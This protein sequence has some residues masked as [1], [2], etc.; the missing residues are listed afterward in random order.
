MPAPGKGW[1]Q[2]SETLHEALGMPSTAEKLQDRID[3]DR[4]ASLEEAEHTVTAS[5]NTPEVAEIA[6]ANL[7]MLAGLA[8]PMVFKYLFPPILITVWQLMLSK[9][10]LPGKQF[11]QIALGIP[12]GFAKTTIVK[13]FV[14]WCILFSSKK[15]IMIISRTGPNAE[16]ILADIIDMLEERNI[17]NLFGHWKLAIEVDRQNLKKFVFRGRTV[18]LAAMGVGGSIRGLNI[19]NE[20]PDIMIFDD[21]QDRDDAESQI[22]SAAI[23]RWMF[24]T[25]MKAKSPHGCI[26]IFLANMFPTEHSILKK[27]KKNKTWTKFISGA[28]LADYTS[29]WEDLRSLDSLIEELNNDIEAGHPEIFFSEVLNDTDVGINTRVDLSA[30]KAWPWSASDQPQGKFIIIDPS[31]NK[32]GGDD[33]AIGYAEVYDGTP[34]LKEVIEERLSPGNTIR[35]ALVMAFEHNTNCI[36]CESNGYQSTLLYWFGIVCNQLGIEGMHLLEVYSSSVS[37]NSRITDMLKSL[38][39]GEIII[40]TNIRSKVNYQIANWNPLKR[41]NVDNVLDLL[42]YL[43]KVL[44]MY[45]AMITTEIDPTAAEAASHRVIENAHPF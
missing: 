9:V 17:I 1:T 44:E 21:I 13:L 20:R 19:K 22:L 4:A 40:H 5:F 24:G 10:E 27:L 32:L 45:G 6:R 41:N 12:R 16:N 23:E 31:A 11:P 38:T 26:F 43:P 37:K 30:I 25:A 3:R 18:I 29:L 2:T 33:V 8:I 35:K 34:A 42:T 28:I 39:S 7:N 36:V 14:L 15:F